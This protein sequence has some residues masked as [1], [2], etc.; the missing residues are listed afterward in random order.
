ML[1]RCACKE[2]GHRLQRP[3]IQSYIPPH[4]GHTVCVDLFY[5]SFPMKISKAF[6]LLACALTR[7]VVVAMLPNVQPT[8]ILNVVANRRISYFGRIALM[9]LGRW[10]GLIGPEWALWAESWSCILIYSPVGESHSNGIA[11][12]RI[13]IIKD[14]FAKLK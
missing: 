5:A 12:R 1:H 13:S 9:V 14:G 11:E 4:P 3:L 6:V 8:T 7:F 10:P 2:K